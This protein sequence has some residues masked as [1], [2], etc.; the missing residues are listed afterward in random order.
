MRK[1][2]VLVATAVAM[3]VG[4]QSAWAVTGATNFSTAGRGEPG[5]ATGTMTVDWKSDNQANVYGY[6]VDHCPANGLG[7][8]LHVRL[9]NLQGAIYEFGTMSYTGGCSESGVSDLIW[10]IAGGHGRIA[11]VDGKMCEE[12][13]NGSKPS[14]CTGWQAVDNPYT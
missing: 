7:V 8:Y 5:Y 14:I 10:V 2:L 6:L 1:L 12:D 3:V 9:Q 13:H 11:H 4:P